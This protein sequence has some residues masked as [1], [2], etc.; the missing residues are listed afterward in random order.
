MIKTVYNTKN[1]NTMNGTGS[2][3]VKIDCEMVDVPVLY[4]PFTRIHK[5][6]MSMVDFMCII[7][8]LKYGKKRKCEYQGEVVVAYK[9]KKSA[10]TFLEVS[11]V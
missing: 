5:A 6:S 3:I 9:T 2:A 4:F 8:R 1:A 11:D 7:E 10:E